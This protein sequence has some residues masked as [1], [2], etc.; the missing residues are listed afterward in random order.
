[1]DISLVVI[2]V[3]FMTI[4]SFYLGSYESKRI[5]AKRT[6]KFKVRKK[7]IVVYAEITDSDCYIETLEGRMKAD[8][9]DYVITGVNGERYPV[10]PDVFKQTYEII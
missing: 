10:K 9:G 3:L 2:F 4:F 8:K 5:Y 7:P 6:G 1:M